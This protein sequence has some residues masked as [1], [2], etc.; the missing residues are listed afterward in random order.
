MVD[1]RIVSL[2]LSQ[3]LD[4]CGITKPMMG[5]RNQ[6]Y[7]EREYLETMHARL[8]GRDEIVYHFGSQSEGTTTPDMNSDLD[9]LTCHQ[10]LPVVLSRDDGSKHR[11]SALVFRDSSTPPR[12]CRLIYLSRGQPSVPEQL[13]S[14]RDSAGR[15][16]LTHGMFSKVLSKLSGASVDHK[17]STA[18]TDSLDLVDA[19]YCSKLPQECKE[20]FNR[21]NTSNWP[22]KKM[23]REI[24]KSGVF[25]LPVGHPDSQLS[26]VEFRFSSNLPERKLM[27]YLNTTQRK[28]YILTKMINLKIVGPSIGEGKLTSYHLKTALFFSIESTPRSFWVEDKTID[29]F[30]QVWLTLQQFLENNFCPHYM[31]SDVNLFQGRITFNEILRLR[32]VTDG[33][34][35]NWLELLLNLS[36]ENI[37]TRLR[38]IQHMNDETN[39]KTRLQAHEDIASELIHKTHRRFQQAKCHLMKTI[40]N[41]KGEEVYKTIDHFHSKLLE[42]KQTDSDI[43]SSLA[44]SYMMFL[45]SFYAS[46]LAARYIEQGQALGEEVYRL[47]DETLDT[48]RISTRLKFASI[49][50]TCGQLSKAAE[51]LNAVENIFSEMILPICGCKGK[52]HKMSAELKRRVFLSKGFLEYRDV[53]YCVIFT[54]FE[55]PCVP[56]FLVYEMNRTQTSEDDKERREKRDDLFWMDMVAVDAKP[57]MYFLQYLTHLAREDFQNRQRALLQLQQYV[58]DKQNEDYGHYE[59]AVNMLGCCFENEGNAGIASQCYLMSLHARGIN[60]AAN[61]HV[62]R[63]RA[64]ASS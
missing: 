14:S 23:L 15:V 18:I 22:G 35:K 60:N 40:N 6:A 51:I 13:P 43:Q 47:F 34:I 19:I 26:L 27:S 45:N 41:L 56:Q 17:V 7:K 3:V 1:Q 54:V 37:G 63:L 12:H 20:W 31:I 49:C 33:I 16:F 42:M 48:D 11:M 62:N 57:F 58:N 29:C 24:E 53:A 5:R 59:T 61:A 2:R 25:L 46:F 64:L 52:Y 55:K 21:P 36:T 44:E 38:I 32:Q 10:G 9:T 4:D 28:V 8:I 50:Y 30:L 39:L